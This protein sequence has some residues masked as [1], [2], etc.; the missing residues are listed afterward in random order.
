[1]EALPLW[2]LVGLVFGWM[3]GYSGAGDEIL[4][5]CA[6]RLVNGLRTLK[7]WYQEPL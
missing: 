7:R 1:M 6:E 2:I 3:L 4:L 5:W